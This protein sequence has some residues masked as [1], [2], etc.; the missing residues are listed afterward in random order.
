MFALM[1]HAWPG[2]VRE[3]RHT[4]ERVCA[5]I[6]PF[7]HLIDASHFEFLTN[8]RA[9]SRPRFAQRRT[10]YRRRRAHFGHGTDTDSQGTS[11]CARE[12][13]GEPRN[14]WESRG[15]RSLKCSSD[16]QSA[17][18]ARRTPNPQLPKAFFM[19]KA[20]IRRHRLKLMYENLGSRAHFLN[21][22]AGA[23]INELRD[24]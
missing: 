19:K 20:K 6:G 14:F 11:Y 13:A 23:E 1:S 2:N 21:K 3:L 5:L 24:R 22:R 17:A 15:A 8:R 9:N 12:T 10:R 7:A 16:T 4:I 18:P